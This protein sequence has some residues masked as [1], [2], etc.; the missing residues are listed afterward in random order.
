MHTP[1]YADSHVEFIHHQSDMEGLDKD[2][3]ASQIT[4]GLI[5]Q[6]SPELLFWAVYVDPDAS[7]WEKA[8]WVLAQYKEV[9]AKEGWHTVMDKKDL[10]RTGTKVILHVED[11]YCIGG[12]L[13]RI[14]RLHALGIR[15][16]GLTHNHTNQFSGG[17]LSPEEGLT[18]LGRQAAGLIADTGMVFDY[19]HLGERAFLEAADSV[20]ALP[21]ISHAGISGVYAS[22]RNVSDAVL[23]KVAERDGYVG[24]GCA[25]SFLAK[26]NGTIDDYLAQI[27]HAATVAGNQRTGIGSDLGGVTS[28]LPE[29]MGT[30]A[31]LSRLADRLP[32]LDILGANL[33]RFLN[34]RSTLAD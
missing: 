31:D 9:I 10:Q 11:I 26:K 22:P 16:I 8:L 14:E 12:D 23:Q 13:T 5:R 27:S 3:L 28:Y 1:F 33:L 29:G 2:F 25:G 24:V 18:A 21:F 20:S 4:P 15:S 6:V 34:E 32:N 30:I 7:A 19:T 17:S